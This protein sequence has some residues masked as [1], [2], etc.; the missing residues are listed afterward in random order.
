M[1]AAGPCP[2]LLFLH[3]RRGALEFPVLTNPQ[4]ADAAGVKHRLSKIKNFPEII[5]TQTLRLY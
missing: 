1:G 5:T 4:L 2:H 3:F